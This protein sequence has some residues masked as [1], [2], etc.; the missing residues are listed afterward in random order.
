[1]IDSHCHLGLCEPDDAALVADAAR[2]GVRRM[3][4]VGI[5]ERASEQAIAAAEAHEGV[6]AAVG[7]HPNGTAG[8]D[9]AAAAR[10]EQLARHPRVVAVG[11]TGLD[12]YRDRAPRDQQRHAFRA[13][14]GIAR[15]VAK[16]V[17]IHVRDGGAT[18]D[19]EALEET[20]E[21]LRAEAVGVTVILH[22]FSAP[23]ERAFEASGWGWYCSF[24]GNVAYP[25]SET[26]REAAREVPDDLLLVETDAPFLSP[27]PVRG[28]PNQPANVVATAE[29]V[30]EVRGVSY[31]QLEAT[32]EANAAR[33]FGWS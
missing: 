30:A 10:I 20:F 6:F 12:Y 14:I 32:V 18:T 11:E 29:A 1:V 17:V 33:V 23:A 26:L 15:R 8:F 24:A 13:H 5:D 9:D 4:N 28:K 7:R 27:Q 21:I 2:V 16:P 19:G 22:C 3:L 25:K 31:P